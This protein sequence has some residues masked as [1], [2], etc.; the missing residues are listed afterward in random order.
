M[1]RFSSR[2]RRNTSASSSS[3]AGAH[4]STIA[5]WSPEYDCTSVRTLFMAGTLQAHR[6]FEE[7]VV[8]AGARLADADATGIFARGVDA[9][10]QHHHHHAGVGIDPQAG[11]GEAEVPEGARPH[12]RAGARSLS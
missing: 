9:V 8:H 1:R 2:A 5:R 12:A 11:A 7:E 6:L 10:G 3:S 4:T